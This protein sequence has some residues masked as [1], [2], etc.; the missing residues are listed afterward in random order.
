MCIEMYHSAA[1]W[2]SDLAL[3]RASQQVGAGLWPALEG[4]SQVHSHDTPALASG[5]IRAQVR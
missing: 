4:L 1:A 2:L 3:A 5:R